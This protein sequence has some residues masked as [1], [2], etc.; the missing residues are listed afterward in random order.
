MF[1]IRIKISILFYTK[2]YIMKSGFFH[3][4]EKFSLYNLTKVAIILIKKFIKDVA[5]GTY[6]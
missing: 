2:K 3:I 1:C 6:E 5:G 4:M